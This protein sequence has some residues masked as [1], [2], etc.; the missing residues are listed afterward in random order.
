MDR[1]VMDA[2]AWIEVILAQPHAKLVRP[3]IHRAE[4]LA[5]SWIRIEAANVILLKAREMK[6][7]EILNRL[8]DVM[9]FPFYKV[10]RGVWWRDAIEMGTRHRI[11]F[12]DAVY[13]SI[14][15]KFSLALLT[16]D[17]LMNRARE[18]ERIPAVIETIQKP[19][20]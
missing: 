20:K 10:P 7:P 11:T 12:Y 13:L 19:R 1:L 2:S 8:Q 18:I 17:N 5:P 3:Y 4:W 15:R 9:R 16:L 6:R 14:A